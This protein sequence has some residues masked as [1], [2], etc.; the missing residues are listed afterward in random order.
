MIDLRDKLPTS[1]VCDDKEY[2]INTDYRVWLRVM[3]DIEDGF[4]L[5]YAIEKNDVFSRETPDWFQDAVIEFMN[6]ENRYPKLEGSGD[7][8]LDLF[9]DGDYVYAAF[10][11]AYRIDLVDIEELHWHKFM[12]LL[13]GLPD[14]TK[15]SKIMGYRSYKKPQKDG[16]EKAMKEAKEA[17]RI[18]ERVEAPAENPWEKIFTGCNWGGE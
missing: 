4:P 11:Q 15:L 7:K 16:Y 12:A 2:P 17:W 9:D 13:R 14:E 8:T 5:A 10:M 1:L 3:M 6:D 18:R